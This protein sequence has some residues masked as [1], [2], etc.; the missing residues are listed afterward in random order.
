LLI[1][2]S[3]DYPLLDIRVDDHEDPIVEL[4]RL[5]AKS[6]ERFQP[7]ATCLPSRGRPAGIT[8]RAIIEE[9]IAKSGLSE[10]K[11]NQK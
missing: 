8:D 5:Y 2:A 1:H 7:F 10:S 11:S 4:K 3:E 6:R 9:E